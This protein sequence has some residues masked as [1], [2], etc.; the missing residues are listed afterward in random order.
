MAAGSKIFLFGDQTTDPRERLRDQLLAG[1]TNVLLC[2]F[3]K[4]VNKALIQELSQ[5][6]WS[7]KLALPTFSSIEDIAER[8]STETA[9]HPGMSSALLYSFRELVR[10]LEN[11]PMLS[12]LDY[13]R[14]SLPAL[15]LPRLPFSQVL[16]PWQ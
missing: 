14:D 10:I 2:H 4:Q 16:F 8:S 5:L 7:E 11:A 9:L 13:V 12:L 15:L 1:R 3:I 6:P